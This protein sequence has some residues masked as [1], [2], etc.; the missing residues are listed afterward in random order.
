LD[1][2]PYIDELKK[3]ANFGWIKE[4]GDLE[5]LRLHLKGIAH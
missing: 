3:D 2:K 5:H 4:T 1:I